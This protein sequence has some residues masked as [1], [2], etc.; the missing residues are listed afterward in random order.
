MQSLTGVGGASLLMSA[1]WVG[2]G[3]ASG[4][5]REEGLGGKDNEA[6][7]GRACLVALGSKERSSLFL[8]TV[9]TSQRGEGLEWLDL[10]GDSGSGGGTV[11]W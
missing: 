1:A 3:E 9:S 10:N 4:V 7:G 2:S 5:R 8:A 6:F 11:E